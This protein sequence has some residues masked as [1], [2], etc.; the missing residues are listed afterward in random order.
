M[1]PLFHVLVFAFKICAV[2]APFARILHAC[3]MIKRAYAGR[4]L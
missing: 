4:D 1:Q 2:P 3:T